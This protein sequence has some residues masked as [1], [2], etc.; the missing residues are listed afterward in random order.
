MT[1]TWQVNGRN[2]VGFDEWVDMDLDYIRTRSTLLDLK[3]IAKT[4]PAVLS[5]KGAS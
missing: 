2:G 3:L 1:C 4:I 5:G